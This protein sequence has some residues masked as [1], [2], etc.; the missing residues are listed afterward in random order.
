MAS[1]RKSRGGQ[2]LTVDDAFERFTPKSSSTMACPPQSD[3]VVGRH[4]P[5]NS[6]P[7]KG[8]YSC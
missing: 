7:R 3:E 8:S 2:A 6:M 4:H 1:S 5:G